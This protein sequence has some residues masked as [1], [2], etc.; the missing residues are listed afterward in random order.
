MFRQSYLLAAILPIA[1]VAGCGD[2]NNGGVVVTGTTASVRFVN[3]TSQPISVSNNGVIASANLAFGASSSCIPVPIANQASLTFTDA[4][5]GATLSGFTPALSA[6]QSFTVVAFTNASGNTQFA[7]LN[8]S[9]NLTSGSGGLRIFNATASGPLTIMAN[10]TAVG[11][12]V[13][14]GTGGTFVSLPAGTQAIT[15]NNGATQVLDLGTV[16][17]TSGVAQTIVVGPAATGTTTLR[18]FTAN[19]C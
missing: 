18:S 19:G 16:T 15:I 13:D 1:F 14:A 4:A 2:K 9:S 7:T 10:G 3:A 5:T 17:I 12:A 11:G 8:N 6:D